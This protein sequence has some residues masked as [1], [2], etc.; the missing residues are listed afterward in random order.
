MDP[1]D[2]SAAARGGTEPG[3]D[4]LRVFAA[5]SLRAA[6]DAL[7]ERAGMAATLRYANARVLADAILGGAPADVFASASPDEPR[8]LA[9][10]GVAA[11]GRAFATNHLVAAVPAGSQLD[12]LDALG[13]PGTRVVLELPGIPLGDY[14]RELLARME[15]LRGDGLA[16]RI[17][18]NVV[19]ERDDVD[20]VTACVYAGE[21]DATILYAT[22]VVGSRGRL[23]AIEPSREAGVE[24][25]YVV[26]ELLAAQRPAAARAWVAL[27]LGPVGRAVLEAAGF[28]PVAARA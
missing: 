21:A 24:A 20:A 25:T 15:E 2:T 17:L 7:A 8:R 1:A 26:S 22:D 23:R 28:G 12:D 13:A 4:P 11:P 18:R 6:F 14:T 16:R 19:A 27:L 3:G 9:E 5:G 10:L